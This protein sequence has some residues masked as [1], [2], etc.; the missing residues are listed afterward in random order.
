MLMLVILKH[1]KLIGDTKMKKSILVLL[2]NFCSLSLANTDTIQTIVN[3]E[4]NQTEKQA[5]NLDFIQKNFIEIPQRKASNFRNKALKTLGSLASGIAN[6]YLYS[7]ITSAVYFDE[8]RSGYRFA[9]EGRTW[10]YYGSET[11]YSKTLKINPIRTIFGLAIASYVSV[12][13]YNFIH[14]YILNKYQEEE[15]KKII[16]RWDQISNLVETEYTDFLNNI[17]INYKLKPS[18]VD[19]SDATKKLR[20]LIEKK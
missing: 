14:S 4:V 9:H 7:K 15:L 6:F 16:E 13:G 3:T 5:K 8:V 10:S 18:D 1:K 2:L 12:L 11:S 20:L 19:L 17:S